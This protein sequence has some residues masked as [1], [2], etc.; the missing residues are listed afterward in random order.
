VL[1]RRQHIRFTMADWEPLRYVSE[2]SPGQITSSPTQ[3]MIKRNFYSVDYALTLLY[4]C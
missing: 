1:L 2:Y 3:A 4:C